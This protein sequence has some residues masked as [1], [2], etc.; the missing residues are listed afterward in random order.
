MYKHI[1]LATKLCAENRRVDLTITGSHSRQDLQL[2]LGL[3]VNGVLNS[4][5]CDL[6]VV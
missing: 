6:P 2:L 5:K 1:L 3:T 4:A